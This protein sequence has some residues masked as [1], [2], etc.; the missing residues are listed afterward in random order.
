MSKGRHLTCPE[1]MKIS[2]T[3]NEDR[4]GERQERRQRGRE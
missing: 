1:A 3:K 2:F 4:G